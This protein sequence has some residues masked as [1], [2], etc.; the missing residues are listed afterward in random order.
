VRGPCERGNAEKLLSSCTTGG[1]SRRAI[2]HGSA[3]PVPK[4]VKF[5]KVLII[6]FNISDRLNGVVVRVLDYRAKGSGFDSRR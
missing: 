6:I 2:F 1:L 5:L 3:E 4:D